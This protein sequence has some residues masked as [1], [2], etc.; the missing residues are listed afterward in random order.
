MGFMDDL[1]PETVHE[2]FGAV[3]EIE[4]GTG[5]NLRHYGNDVESVHGIDP[6]ATQG[7]RKVEED[8]GAGLIG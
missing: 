1:R 4:F 2:A 7:V 8:R 6:L 3:L 5:R